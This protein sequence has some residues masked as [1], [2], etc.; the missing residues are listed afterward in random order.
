MKDLIVGNNDGNVYFYKNIGTNAAPVFGAACE[1]LKTITNT[2]INAYYGSRINFV[3]WRGD[4]D[5]DLLISGYDGWV[6]LYEN[7]TLEIENEKE[8]SLVTNGIKIAPNPARSKAVINYALRNRAL[9]DVSVYSADGRLVAR[10]FNLYADAGSHQLTW[11]VNN[12]PAGVYIVQ[13]KAGDTITSS[14]IVIA[15]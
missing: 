9:V 14:R 5:I 1:T 7:A 6:Q 2:V 11:N 4:G 3:D 13:L 12:L 10:P 15:H 8:N